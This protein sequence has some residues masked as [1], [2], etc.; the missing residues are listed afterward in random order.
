[1]SRVARKKYYF[2]DEK[3]EGWVHKF[4]CGLDIRDGIT[5]CGLMTFKMKQNSVCYSWKNTTCKTCI[6]L[7]PKKRG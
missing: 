7:A 5:A 4:G 6:R 2:G 1:M 3:R